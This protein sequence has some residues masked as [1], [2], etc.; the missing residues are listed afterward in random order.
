[1][2]K[3]LL[4]L[5]FSLSSWGYLLA[6]LSLAMGLLLLFALVQSNFWRWTISTQHIN[7]WGDLATL[8]LVLILVHTY[9]IQPVEQPMFVLLKCLPI[10]FAPVLLAQYLTRQTQI[11]LSILFYALRKKQ[12]EQKRID[13]IPVYAA[14][15]MLSSGAANVTDVRYFALASAFF[16]LLLAFNRPKQHYFL[17]WLL[18]ISLSAGL[19]FFGQMGLRQLHL[20]IEQKSIQLLSD[21]QTDSF[22]AETAIGDIGELKL[23]SRIT[24]RLKADG[25]LLL[26]QAS[27]DRYFGQTW[28]ASNRQFHI[29]RPVV[30]AGQPLKTLQILQQSLGQKM[31]AL[32]D[33]T[34][35]LKG[36]DDAV[37]QYSDLGAIKIE[38]PERTGNYQVFY[39]GQRTGKPTPYDLQIPAQHRDWLNA[40]H[41]QLKLNQLPPKIIAER[42]K[43]YFQ[44]NFFYSLSSNK[45]D[46]PDLALKNFILN[47]K[48]GHCEYFATA[49]VLLLRQAGIPARF[50][51]GY[52]VSEYVPEDDLYLVRSRDAHAWA[53]AYM[54]G[55]WQPVDATPAQWQQLEAKNAKGVWQS[56]TDTWSD[57]IFFLQ[58]LPETRIKQ[59]KLAFVCLGLLY[60]TRHWWF[61]T[62][63]KP[64][65]KRN[66]VTYAGLDSEFYLLEQHLKTSQDARLANESL[67][68]WVNRLNQTELIKLCQLH[69]Q[70]RFDPHGL[71]HTERQQ[72]RQLALDY[73]AQHQIKQD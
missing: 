50:A 17:L 12:T 53:I 69:Y 11:P 5:A 14:I 34:V 63:I 2:N 57:M 58:Q 67:Q 1:M 10:V 59:L 36:L 46:N 60:F 35:E 15:T 61:K 23:S 32:P 31:L 30:D 4:L 71:T 27:Y 47:T 28:L 43:D 42:I 13:F 3:S 16:V 64:Q 33:G 72:L 73:I 44:A 62:R 51:T 18:L 21:L 7:R 65:A 52:S 37:L 26:H 22:K 56:L 25:Q 41:K 19:G 24:F 55:I 68:Q 9:V 29:E 66:P 54:N 39:T 8:L 45:E 70:L 40:L 48:A 49:S 6:N 20:F 38:A